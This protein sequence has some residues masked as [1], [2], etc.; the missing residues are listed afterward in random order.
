MAEFGSFILSTHNRAHLL[1]LVCASMVGREG[2]PK[3]ISR[4]GQSLPRHLSH[5]R[6]AKCSACRRLRAGS[7]T[8]SCL[9]PRMQ[10]KQAWST[11]MKQPTVFFIAIGPLGPQPTASLRA[12]EL[13]Q[14]RKV[15]DGIGTEQLLP[16]EATIPLQKHQ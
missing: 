15:N 10:A 16:F 1:L 11:G 2:Q 12:D 3:D 7:S 4:A 9:I 8:E 13:C 6:L 14:T 5:L